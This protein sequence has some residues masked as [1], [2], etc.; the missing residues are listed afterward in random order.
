[1]KR[2]SWLLVC[3]VL[4]C[5]PEVSKPAR[6]AARHDALSSGVVISEV[7]GGA[8][9]SGATYRHDFVELFNRGTAPVD[10]S[11]WS[12]QY[13]SDTGGSWQPTSLAG[14]TGPLQPGQYL[15]VRMAT[16]STGTALPA[17]DVSGAS[18][19]SGTAGKVAL[20]SSMTG[21]S[22]TCPSSA[23]IV[24]LVGYGAASNCSE[25]GPT[26]N[27]SATTSV[28]RIGNGCT[29]TDSNANDF[30]VSGPSPQGSSVT[31]PCGTL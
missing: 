23:S 20:V 19:M 24:D 3:V 16:G 15:L 4:G 9:G 25:G 1:M 10:V 2:S 12:V 27:T 14:F 17:H 11:G 7:Y 31:V 30:I 22:G 26:A 28:S 8:A 29:E 21:L 18:A 13:T 6:F 5:T